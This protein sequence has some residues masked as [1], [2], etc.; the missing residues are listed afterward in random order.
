VLRHL[1]PQV[2]GGVHLQGFAPAQ[3]LRASAVTCTVTVQCKALSA[4]QR[5]WQVLQL[6]AAKVSMRRDHCLLLRPGAL[7]PKLLQCRADCESQCDFSRA[8]V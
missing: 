7:A 5:L 3:V 1:A 8:V 6:V 2:C 4:S